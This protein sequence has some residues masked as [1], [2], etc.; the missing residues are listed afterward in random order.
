MDLNLIFGFVMAL[1]V[2]ITMGVIGGGG[3]ILTVPVFVYFL[4]IEPI[5]ATAYSLFV[6]GSTALVGAVWSNHG[7]GICEYDKKR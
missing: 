7:N 1:V 5:I 4:S 6:V 2:G 3:S